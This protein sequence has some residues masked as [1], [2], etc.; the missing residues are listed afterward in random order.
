[1]GTVTVEE[2]ID[3]F[4]EVGLTD[5]DMKK[6]HQVFEARNPEGHLSFLQWLGLSEERIKKVRDL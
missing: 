4:R 5:E 3:L 1:M 6:W 2:W